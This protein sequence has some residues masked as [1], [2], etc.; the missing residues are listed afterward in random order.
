MEIKCPN[1][2]EIVD[3]PDDQYSG[4]PF[5]PNCYYNFYEFEDAQHTRWHP[6]FNSK[7]LEGENDNKP[8]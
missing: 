5:C 6:L 7:K 4:V 3:I 8:E 1:C 2:D